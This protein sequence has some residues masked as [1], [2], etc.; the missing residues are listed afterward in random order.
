MIMPMFSSKTFATN[1]EMKFS[2]RFL[3]VMSTHIDSNNSIDVT[4]NLH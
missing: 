4:N 2:V 1:I 3:G